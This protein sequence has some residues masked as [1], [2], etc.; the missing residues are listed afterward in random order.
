MWTFGLNFGMDNP[1]VHQNDLENQDK[2]KKQEAKDLLKQLASKGQDALDRQLDKTDFLTEAEQDFVNNI[3]LEWDKLWKEYISKINLDNISINILNM[4][5]DDL[6]WET[7][8]ELL[9]IKQERENRQ[10]AVKS[11]EEGKPQFKKPTEELKELKLDTIPDTKITD[12]SWD[13]PTY[14]ALKKIMT[15]V[16]E[17]HDKL[18][19][20]TSDFSYTYSMNKLLF[21][22]PDWL[23]KE[24]KHWWILNEMSHEYTAQV[25]FTWVKEALLS[26]KPE[27]LPDG[28]AD[29]I[30]SMISTW[31]ATWAM[32]IK[33]TQDQKITMSDIPV[34]SVIDL[35]NW[36]TISPTLFLWEGTYR[37]NTII[38][39]PKALLSQADK[40][41]KYVNIDYTKNKWDPNHKKNEDRFIWEFE[42]ADNNGNIKTSLQRETV[43]ARYKK[44]FFSKEFNNWDTKVDA[45]WFVWA[46]K[47]WWVEWNK[48]QR[49]WE[50]SWIWWVELWVKQNLITT[51]DWW[52][53]Y[54]EAKWWVMTSTSWKTWY[55]WEV[56][57]WYKAKDWEN[58]VSLNLEV[59]NHYLDD[60]S[61]L[62]KNWAWFNARIWNIWWS[63]VDFNAWAFH[64]ST[65]VDWDDSIKNW[66]VEESTSINA[67]FSKSF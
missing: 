32:Y 19:V 17:V 18:P 23:D 43:L 11:V 20:S 61:M 46:Q 36:N 9:E 21:P 63:W 2:E 29:I 22:D 7:V 25:I 58:N 27:W 35:W 14:N 13:S 1:E 65:S 49:R 3:K 45:S 39:N 51:N 66:K 47:I 42:L 33:E 57:I 6:D 37:V 59:D 56:W 40:F 31:V 64:W 54:T 12:N 34:V 44:D 30:A 15:K 24:S 48:T 67:W 55:R 28:Y 8:K 50:L 10:L 41:V 26:Q 52:N 16:K 60:N 38:K 4:L 53:V 62:Y 5:I